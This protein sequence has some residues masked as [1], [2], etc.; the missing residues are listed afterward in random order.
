LTLG[1]YSDSD[2]TNKKI[3]LYRVKVLV[4]YE[5]I[6]LAAII[7]Y[8]LTEFHFYHILQVTKPSVSL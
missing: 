1:Y 7:N 4:N 8:L 5:F 6:R 2:I 3:N